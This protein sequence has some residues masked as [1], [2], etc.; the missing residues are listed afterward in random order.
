MARLTAHG[1]TLDVPAGWDARIYKRPAAGEVAATDTDGPPAPPGAA[2]H[3]VVHVATIPMPPDMGD[4]GSAGLDQLGRDDAFI[5]V[6]D[7]GPEAV[8][9]ALFGREGM[10][11]LLEPGDFDSKTLQRALPGQSGVQSFFTESGR[12]CCLYVVLGAHAN[13]RRIVPRV[14]A[15]LADL[16]IE[17]EVAGAQSATPPPT[18]LEAIAAD[19]DLSEF[20]RLLTKAGIADQLTGAGPLTVFAPTTTALRDATNLPAIEADS[21]R[22]GRV[23]RFHVVA[24]VVDIGPLAAQGPGASTTAATLEGHPITVT[25]GAHEAR[26]ENVIIDPQRIVAGNGSVYTIAGLLEPPT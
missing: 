4:F 11:R 17:P 24:D 14:N 5:V 21:A 9:K 19:P 2:T 18:V 3:A 16:Q 20:A 6:F 8:G 7:H 26:V 25:I 23:V 10:P 13:S 15:V 12:A 22:L 1:F